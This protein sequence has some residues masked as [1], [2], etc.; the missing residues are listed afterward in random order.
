MNEKAVI[1]GEIYDIYR[2]SRYNGMALRADEHTIEQLEQIRDK[3]KDLQKVVNELCDLSY[4]EDDNH[5]I[6]E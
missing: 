3:A 2:G 6:G 5:M 1:I 4:R